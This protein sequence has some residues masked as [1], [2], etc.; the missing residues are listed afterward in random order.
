MFMKFYSRKLDKVLVIILCI[1]NSSLMFK[2]NLVVFS[3]LINAKKVI[4]MLRFPF[5]LPININLSMP[6]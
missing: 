2:G 1:S 4:F 5:L 3:T 6:T